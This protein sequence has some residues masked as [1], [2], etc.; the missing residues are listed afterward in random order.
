MPKKKTNKK[1][2]INADIDIDKAKQEI[3]E[4]IKSIKVAPI[5]DKEAL[6]FSEK[7]VESFNKPAGISKRIFII[8]KDILCFGIATGLFIYI[9][10]SSLLLIAHMDNKF[11]RKASQFVPIP[12][13]ISNEGILGYYEYHDLR[14]DLSISK[15]E[16]N[17]LLAEYLI[18]KNYK[19]SEKDIGP[20]FED[21]KKDV[22]IWKIVHE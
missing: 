1:N 10:Y 5:Y 11:F 6:D 15:D 14:R 9:I 8:V 19:N 17:H 12:A 20:N 7:I 18:Y 2:K 4:R 22:R 3:S 16:F 21:K 13:V